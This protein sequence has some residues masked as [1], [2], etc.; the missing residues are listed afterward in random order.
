MPLRAWSLSFSYSRTGKNQCHSFQDTISRFSISCLSKLSSFNK[1]SHLCS[2]RRVR[3]L[4]PRLYDIELDSRKSASSRGNCNSSTPNGLRQVGA[5]L[6]VSGRYSSGTCR[7]VHLCLLR[8]CIMLLL[9]SSFDIG[10]GQISYDGG[11]NLWPRKS[12]MAVSCTQSIGIRCSSVE[13]KYFKEAATH[14][15][16]YHPIAL[17]K[18]RYSSSYLLESI[19]AGR[20][21]F[22]IRNN[23]FKQA[24]L[25]FS[26]PYSCPYWRIC[27]TSA[28]IRRVT[29]SNCREIIMGT[30]SQAVTEQR[31]F[32]ETI[33]CRR[34]RYDSTIRFN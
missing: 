9:S 2:L 12:F 23:P 8:C 25:F 16:Y 21:A 28:E 20:T 4:Y 7:R 31:W 32:K 30:G 6:I 33:Y 27:G 19:L 17:R 34:Y 3:F 26:K 14:F 11:R 13:R 24:V 18:I 1:E 10:G 29:V 22:S 5:V 15:I